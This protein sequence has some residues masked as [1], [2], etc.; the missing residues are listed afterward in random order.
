MSENTTIQLQTSCILGFPFERYNQSFKFIVNGE[1][2]ET[3]RVIADLLSN[4]VRQLHFIDPTT[5]YFQI[6]TKER[7]NFSIILQLADFKGVTINESDIP[8]LNEVIQLLGNE[9]I[10]ISNSKEDE[11]DLNITNVF[12]RLHT[13]LSLNSKAFKNFE[14]SKE[15][16]FISNHFYDI[17]EQKEDE[18]IKVNTSILELILLN[19]DLKLKSED[20]LV[21]FIMKLTK[22]DEENSVLYDYVDFL[23]VS[24]PMMIEFINNYD[25]NRLDRT[26]WE[27]LSMRLKQEI[28]MKTKQTDDLL[29]R[30]VKEKVVQI[31]YEKNNEFKGIINYIRE[32]FNTN[33]IIHLS[34]SSNYNG[35]WG[36]YPAQNVIKFDER[37]VFVSDDE[38]NSWLCIDFKSHKV[39]PMSYSIRSCIFA[40]NS[41][42]PKSWVIE[43][44]DDNSKWEIVDEQKNCS[45]LNGSNLVHTF[46]I[47]KK[48]EEK[49]FRYLRIR[50]TNPNWQNNH[51]LAFDSIEF[52]GTF[53]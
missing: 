37:C 1:T 24:L 52:Y 29:H 43:G 3:N 7:G 16:E 13:K 11:I 15:I 49:E 19:D 51:Y 39:A 35:P 23:N 10:E 18:L 44:S 6:S 22:I 31:Q 4:E 27:S 50:L 14:I 2:F 12:N 17:I 5:D 32:N 8:F 26:I 25:Y 48:E 36:F 41:S 42:H 21:K 46:D 45:L 34:S 28:Q 20:Q 9:S 40:T 33:E 53:Q 30:Y 38:Q 47:L